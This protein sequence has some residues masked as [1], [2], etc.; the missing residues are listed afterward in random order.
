M[1]ASPTIKFNNN[2]VEMPTLSATPDVSTRDQ[3][4]VDW[5]TVEAVRHTAP[6]V[7]VAADPEWLKGAALFETAVS[8]VRSLANAGAGY[9]RFLNFNIFPGIS[10]AKLTEEGPW[11]FKV[12]DEVMN[13]FMGAVGN[14]SV[15]VDIET[16]PA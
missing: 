12:M 14:A 10:C 15:V 6:S 7:L 16:S 13:S 11:D 5:T 2:G 1:D 9:I 3:L 8:G 4:Y